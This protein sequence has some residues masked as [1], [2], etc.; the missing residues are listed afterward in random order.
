MRKTRIAA[1]LL[2]LALLLTAAAQAADWEIEKPNAAPELYEK[3]ESRTIPFPEGISR[4]YLDLAY[5][6]ENSTPSEKLH[7]LLPEE[8]EGPWPVLISVHGG[9]FSG[10]NSTRKHEV[11]FTQK[12]A[13]AGLAHG[14]AVACVDYTLQTSKGPAVF[15][16]A[17]QEV[18]AAVRY[19]RSVAGEYNL[20]PDRI[21]LMGESAGAMLVSL[22]ALTDGEG[23]SDNPEFG[24]MEYSAKPQAVIL[25]YTGARS[26]KNAMTAGLFGVKQKKLT[27]EMVWQVDPIEHIDASDPPVFLEHGTADSTLNYS[28]SI[29]MYEALTAAGVAN[30]ELHLYEGMEH[31]VAWFQ[32]DYVNEQHFRWLDGVL[33][34]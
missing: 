4:I 16:L 19:I 33:Q 12:A 25:Q 7:L 9:A 24:R 6:G 21:A 29:D 5:C 26:G 18:R 30:C 11:S 23:Y 17:I 1:L 31:A 27:D 2:A 3:P 15:P 10:N 28:N 8:G 13:F 20:D 32:S 34:R 22:A 14:Y